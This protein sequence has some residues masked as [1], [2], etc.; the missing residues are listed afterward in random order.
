[1]EQKKANVRHDFFICHASE[2]KKKFAIPIYEGLKKSKV[3]CWLDMYEIDYGD[4][5]IFK[6]QEGIN[7]SSYS[8]I[9]LSNNWLKENWPKKELF[10]LL[11]REIRKNKT[12]V[13]PLIVDNEETILDNIP[14]IEGKYYIKHN[15]IE[16][17]INKLT[18]FT[19]RKGDYSVKDICFI[20]SEYPPNVIG[21]LGVHVNELSNAL[22]NSKLNVDIVLPSSSV[23]Y[24]NINN[25]INLL[26][27]AKIKASYN[28]PVSWLNFAHH[29]ANKICNLP[30]L[31]DVVH[32]HDWVTILAGIICKCKLKIPLVYHLHLPNKRPFCS[33]IE[34]LGLVC[35]DLVT[36]NSEFIKE[37]VLSRQLK[38]NKIKV[39]KNGVN[40][41]QFKPKEPLHEDNYILYVGR[42][43]HQKGVD[44]L[45][46]AFWY[47]TKKYPD[48]KLKVVGVGELEDYL[49][50]LCVNLMIADKVLF[51]GLKKGEELVEI[52][53]K[54]KMVIVPSIYEPFGM[55]VIEAFAC[56]KPVIATNF[57]GLK[58]NIID[59]KTGYLFEKEDYLDLAQ[60]IMN[61]LHDDKRRK[62]FGENGYNSVI[63]NDYN[64]NSISKV[65]IKEYNE[66][67]NKKLSIFSSESITKFKEQIIRLAKEHPEN[68]PKKSEEL[69]EEIFNVFNS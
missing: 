27:L 35:S 58:E 54:S 31:P 46:R 44:I 50:R 42:L 13:I 40:L 5:I 1:M 36:V 66:I 51:E 8:L 3:K 25:G 10:S 65:F 23:N 16:D 22:T 14:L 24:D 59:G 68:L 56:K 2:D 7:R 38:I 19:K 64:W 41:N 63:N 47:V 48:I 21:G 17:T 62:E 32:C 33:S 15:S 30:L 6:I 34:N 39:V 26:P 55:T 52:Y 67:A 18:E 57:M 11:S 53:Q 4:D 20:S 37:E 60:W 9:I 45:L 29:A 69:F 49:K 28:K 12:I 43:V 61:L